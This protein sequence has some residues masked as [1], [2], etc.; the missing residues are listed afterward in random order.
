VFCNRS[1]EKEEEL[2]FY[3]H[4]ITLKK[5]IT[6]AHLKADEKFISTSSLL[7]ISEGK[8]LSSKE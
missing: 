3:Q 1:E 4:L 6:P 8:Y 2:K 7:Y 5:F